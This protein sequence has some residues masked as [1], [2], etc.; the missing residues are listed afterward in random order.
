MRG[1]RP[2]Q[3]LFLGRYQ[4]GICGLGA[5]VWGGGRRGE[6]REERGAELLLDRVEARWVLGVSCPDPFSLP[7][8][9][10]SWASLCRAPTDG[11]ASQSH[12]SHL[13]LGLVLALL[14]L[15]HG[16]VRVGAGLGEADV[17]DGRSRSLPLGAAAG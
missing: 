12:A 2:R 13:V 7:N 6:E 17:E 16:E 10:P 15:R 3:G 5:D 1:G 4:E 14:W 11:G 8:A 9:Q